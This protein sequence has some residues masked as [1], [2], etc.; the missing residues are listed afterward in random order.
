LPGHPA[1]AL[2]IFHLFIRPILVKMTGRSEELS[3]KIKAVTAEK[4]FPAKG[5][6]TFVTVTLK[7][8]KSGKISAYPVPTGQSGAI[9]TLA[10]ADGFIEI[11]ESQQ[12]IDAGET[13]TVQLFK[14]DTYYSL[15]KE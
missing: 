12:F 15:M 2:L 1:S 4:L 10:R 3:I 9:T 13:V 11:H 14:P 7:R 6:R 8:N 5:R